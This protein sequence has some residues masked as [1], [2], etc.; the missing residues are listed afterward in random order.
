MP[1]LWGTGWGRVSEEENLGGQLL[2]LLVYAP[3]GLLLE[4]RDLIPKLADRGRGQVALTQLAGKVA[5]NR[6]RAD[7]AQLFRQLLEAA[8]AAV[9]LITP[10]R[11]EDPDELDDPDEPED[12]DPG[13]PI[14]NYNAFSAPQ[15]LEK[16]EALDQR[17]LDTILAYEQA[18]RDRQ[19]V[20][21][22]I[23][24]LS[25]RSAPPSD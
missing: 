6:G 12:D 16:L 4:A 17:Q 18:H 25:A 24:Q 3:I 20:T 11:H 13:L 10:D 9:D 22:R 23:K 5:G 8:G 1:T 7:T 21:N 15:L 14:E 2:D 19:T